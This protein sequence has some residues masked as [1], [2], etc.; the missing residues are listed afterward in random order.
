[1]IAPRIPQQKSHDHRTCCMHMFLQSA[2][3]MV[4]VCQNPL[5]HG[6]C[7]LTYMYARCICMYT[8]VHEVYVHVCACARMCVFMH[9]V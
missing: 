4:D 3:E 6:K 5:I 1:M 7:I 8:H 2:S 9:L